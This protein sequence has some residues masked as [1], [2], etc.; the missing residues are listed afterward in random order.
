MNNFTW[1]SRPCDHC[2]LQYGCPSSTLAGKRVVTPT[3]FAQEVILKELCPNHQIG[4]S[5]DVTT[6]E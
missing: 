5:E 1:E 3:L 2:Q 6:D 4:M